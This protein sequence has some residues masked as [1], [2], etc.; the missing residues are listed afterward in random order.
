MKS[1]NRGSIYNYEYASTE[2][3]TEVKKISAEMNISI[4]EFISRA[5]DLYINTYKTGRKLQCSKTKN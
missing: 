3:M 4:K 1:K 2:Q 5:I